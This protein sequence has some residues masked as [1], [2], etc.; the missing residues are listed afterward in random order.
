[1]QNGKEFQRLWKKVDMGKYSNHQIG[2]LSGGQFQ[3]VLLAR[4]LA[5]NAISYF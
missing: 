2:E 3:R 5:Q 4:C 1:M